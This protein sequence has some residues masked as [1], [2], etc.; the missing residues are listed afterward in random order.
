MRVTR[1]QVFTRG[2]TQ[3]CPNCGARTLFKAGT[4]FQMNEQCPACGFHFEG[5]AG[6]EGFYLRATSINFGVTVTCFLF[7]VVL[8]VFARKISVPTAEVLAVAGALVVPGLFYRT[9]R[10]WA[11]LNYYIFAPDELPAN[12]L[13]DSA[14]VT[15]DFP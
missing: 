5:V 4:L 8:L 15:S 10:S 3:R 12:Q 6:R 14:S 9:S 7:P 13:T 11:L 2:L 1:A